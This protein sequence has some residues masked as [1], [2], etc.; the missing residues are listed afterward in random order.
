MSKFFRYSLFSAGFIGAAYFAFKLPLNKEI[1]RQNKS[2]SSIHDNPFL[3]SA[4]FID[5]VPHWITEFS[6]FPLSEFTDLENPA[7]Q[8]MR[9]KDPFIMSDGTKIPLRRVVVFFPKGDVD[10]I[11]SYVTDC[12][13]RLKW[14]FNYRSFEELPKGNKDSCTP[15]QEGLWESGIEK[16]PETST[17]LVND[18]WLAHRVGCSGFARFGVEDRLFVYYRW[19]Y[20]HI[21]SPLFESRKKQYKFYNIIYDGSDKMKKM[22]S[23]NSDCLAWVK[24][25]EINCS[26]VNCSMNYQHIVLLPVDDA[27]AQLSSKS[28]IFS[29]ILGSGSVLSRDTAEKY[30]SF[31]AEPSVSDKTKCKAKIEGTL[32]MITSVNDVGVPAVLPLWVEKKISS[33]VSVR[34]FK[35]LLQ[36]ALLHPQIKLHE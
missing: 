34:V 22:Y 23:E 16:L 28:S 35:S 1:T 19:C 7:I 15:K 5:T 27:N 8:I 26:C 33:Q 12:S 36:H 32:L 9:A 29:S 10:T 18:G 6:N 25:H 24:S 17:L 2:P 21:Y 31:L 30:I 4:N 14:D 3:S 20:C 11:F 13:L